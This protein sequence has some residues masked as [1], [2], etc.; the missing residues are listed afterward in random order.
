[1]GTIVVIGLLTFGIVKGGAAVVTRGLA[2][3]TGTALAGAARRALG[4]MGPGKGPVYGTKAH[5]TFEAEVKALGR[6]DLHT[7]VSYLNGKEVPHGT[8]G[9]VRF[10]VVEGPRAAPTAAYD[11]KTGGATLTPQRVQELRAQLPPQSQNIPITE[12]RGD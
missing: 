10:D 1:M 8:K 6:K 5:T 7:E 11:F 9:S 3:E 4:K 12:I 2:T